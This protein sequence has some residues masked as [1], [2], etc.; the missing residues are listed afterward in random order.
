[1]PTTQLSE[2]AQGARNKKYRLH[3]AWKCSR[4]ATNEDVLHILF[5]TSDPYISS[6]NKPS[7][8]I[9]KELFEEAKE[10]L[11]IESDE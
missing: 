5:Y 1:M 3:H 7:F 10:L 6:L 11:E 9:S 4:S 2:D 8:L